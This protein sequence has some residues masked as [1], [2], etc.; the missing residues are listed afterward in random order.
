MAESKS[1]GWRIDAIELEHFRGIGDRET[2]RLDG[3]PTLITGK[4]GVGKS[5]IAQAVQWTLFKKFPPGVLANTKHTSFL[6]PVGSKKKKVFG[7]VVVLT[8]AGETLKASR[9][10]RDNQLELE[11]SGPRSLLDDNEFALEQLLGLDWDTFTRAVLIQQNRMRELL[12][13]DPKERNNV[14]DR[15]LGTE[16][17]GD[18]LDTLK[19]NA[20]RKAV[21]A[22]QGALA[23]AQERHNAKL[24]Q[25]QEQLSEAQ[26]RAQGLGFRRLQLEWDGLIEAYEKVGGRLQ[27]LAGKYS[28]EIAALP[29]V[30]DLKDADAASKSCREAVRLIRHESNIQQQMVPLQERGAQL[31]AYLSAWTET[32][33]SLVGWKEKQNALVKAHGKVEVVEKHAKSLVAELEKLKQQL[34]ATDKLR[35]LLVLGEAVVVEMPS[36][37]C[38][39]CE[40]DVSS[41]DKLPDRLRQRIDLLASDTADELEGLVEKRGEELD[42]AEHVLAEL[43]E[44]VEKVQIWQ[45]KAGEI[46]VDIESYLESGE[47]PEQRVG[48][49]LEREIKTVEKKTD[50]LKQGVEQMERDLEGIEN[51]E[52]IIKEGL[53][54][55]LRLREQ[56]REREESWDREKAKYQAEEARATELEQFLVRVDQIRR[57]LMAAKE[58]LAGTRLERAIPRAQELYR[59]MVRHPVFETLN[60]ETIKKASKVDYSFLVSAD[61]V[62]DSQ[63]DAQYVLSDGQMTATAVGLLFALAE[64]TSHELD[65]LYLD[66]PSHSLDYDGKK[67]MAQVVVEIASRRQVVVSSQDDDF[68]AALRTAGFNDIGRVF[69]LSDWSGH[70]RIKQSGL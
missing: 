19:M 34:I 12:L 48:P 2:F 42:A 29:G 63:R 53:L 18:F 23:A 54:P 24:E 39:M 62:K 69:T 44:A 14:M 61:K 65:L 30:Q 50:G 13:A 57:A 25:L 55:V 21:E 22:A 58:E 33:E 70:P 59:A 66:D 32:L 7:G 68:V 36:G 16:A 15:L 20:I 40:Q 9:H 4:N 26:E 27:T 1:Q 56:I 47:L 51:Q 6:T 60:I 67:A 37:T 3:L 43:S 64:S 10:A 17:I 28:V 35:Q 31:S 41:P 45:A 49:T 11:Y 38:P 5:T 46:R 52:R 8:R